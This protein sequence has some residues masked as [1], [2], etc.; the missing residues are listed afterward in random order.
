M[1]STQTQQ[2][3]GRFLRTFA[4]AGA[5]F[6]TAV[7]GAFAIVTGDVASA[8]QIMAPFWLTTMLLAVGTYAAGSWL[9]SRVPVNATTDDKVTAT[10]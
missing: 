3:N 1:Q 9:G 7:V 8:I 2:P 10:A 5:A 6:F 4:V